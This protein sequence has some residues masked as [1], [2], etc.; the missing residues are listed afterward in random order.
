MFRTV[1]YGT[2]FNMLSA[3]DEDL[4]MCSCQ[5]HLEVRYFVNAELHFSTYNDLFLHLYDDSH[6]GDLTYVDWTCSPNKNTLCNKICKSPEELSV[7][8]EFNLAC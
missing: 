6:T 8:I 4:E 7:I 5:Q 3:T 1:G 2:F